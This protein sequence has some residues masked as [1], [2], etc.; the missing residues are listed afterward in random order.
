[1]SDQDC[2]FIIHNTKNTVSFAAHS[3]GGY[4]DPRMESTNGIDFDLGLDSVTIV[5]FE[6]VRNRNG[7][8]LTA[9]AFY[10][11]Q[12]GAGAA[13]TVTSITTTD[14]IT[15]T[16]NLH[17]IITLKEWTTIIAD[18]EDLAGNAIESFGNV[19]PKSNEPD[20]I[21]VGFLPIDTDQSGQVQALDLLVFRQIF[22]STLDP[23]PG[24]D[25]DYID[26][27]RDSSIQALD[28]LIW[29]Q[30]FYGTGSATQVWDGVAM[31]NARP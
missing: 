31:N 30:L 23:S 13:P 26:M 6:P 22:E 5:F 28:F 9:L 16:V 18:V 25:E 11:T 17:R 24:I 29:R 1:M 20:R 2:P 10:A 15:V 3:F 14:N 7:L 27:N 21:D 12:T 4:I 19:G 8:P